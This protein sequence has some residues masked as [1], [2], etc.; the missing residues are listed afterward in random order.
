MEFFPYRTLLIGYPSQS[1]YPSPTIIPPH[2]KNPVDLEPPPYKDGDQ[3]V[4]K[5]NLNRSTPLVNRSGTTIHNLRLF[6]TKKKPNISPPV[7]TTLL[8]HHQKEIMASWQRCCCHDLFLMV[9][10]NGGG[11]CIGF[12]IDFWT[13]VRGGGYGWPKVVIGY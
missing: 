2:T 13:M 11:E 5:I 8:Q 3:K 12:L 10:E 6:P 4:N 9:Q 7:T 1:H